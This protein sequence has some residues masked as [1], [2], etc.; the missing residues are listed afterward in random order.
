MSAAPP[1]T[2]A[3]RRRLALQV[4]VEAGADGRVP[5]HEVFPDG[6]FVPA[7]DSHFER[8]SAAASRFVARAL[9]APDA[10]VDAAVAAP[11]RERWAARAASAVDGA[12]YE[13]GRAVAVIEAL[14]AEKP[15]LELRRA[16]PPVSMSVQGK[17][18][19]ML[20]AKRRALNASADL[21]ST[22]AVDLEKW[23]EADNAFCDSFL[24]LRK[25]CSAVRCAP[26]GTPLIDVGDGDFTAVLRP[27][28]APAVPSSTAELDVTDSDAVM[29]NMISAAAPTVSVRFPFPTFLRFGVVRLDDD[30]R[31][32]AAPV[33][34]ES[35]DD[36][37]DFS[38]NAIVR[39]VR[40]ARVA[41][42]RRQTFDRLAREAA[43]LPTSV[44]LTTNAVGVESGPSDIVRI[45]RTLRA[46]S[47][48]SIGVGSDSITTN[49]AMGGA[50]ALQD[51]SL[52]QIVS[53]HASLMQSVNGPDKGT[54][55]LDRVLAAT[56]GRSVLRNT[57]RVLDS[58]VALL[59]VRVEWTRG[60]SRAEEARARIFSSSADGDGPSRALATV[61][62][63]SSINN[64]G[65]AWN[66]G[67]VRITPAFG[68]IISAPDNPNAR[69]RAAMPITHSSSITG[70]AS[71]SGLDDVPRS[72]V[73]PVTGGEIVSVLT[74]LL[75]IRLLDALETVARAGEAEML[76]VDRQ[77][78]VVVV[79]APRTGRTLR[80]KVWPRGS[81][82]GEE[83][84]GATAWLNGQRVADFPATAC[85]RVAA[86]RQLLHKL[87]QEDVADAKENGGEANAS[88]ETKDGD[89]M[90][91]DVVLQSGTN[92]ASTPMMGLV[93]MGAV[94]PTSNGTDHGGANGLNGFM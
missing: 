22:R 94:P 89:Q 1:E 69:G 79:S 66:N 81:S 40:L 71:A 68:V 52:L 44:D 31:T 15:L 49:S 45:E 42:F 9:A 25:R 78:F 5:V 43:A 51:A 86:W 83:V 35:A 32:T 80:A 59:R 48:Q 62:P 37:A 73:C 38:L 4:S 23:L 74:L 63:V 72:Y 29:A 27:D 21:L 16:L 67:H 14:R 92:A 11:P 84:P 61:E 33:V 46:S 47:A 57:E 10:D 30:F 55:I 28:D 56:S 50:D 2:G 3:K 91:R 88:A 26:S 24:T 53:V 60:S 41:A 17:A 64:G 82:V 70:A 20:M 13:L 34:L 87:V 90:M 19:A 6:S 65:S 39:R 75:C 12:L 54:K 77:C 18:G 85:G 8:T 76:D 58:A 7:T 36:A 93:G